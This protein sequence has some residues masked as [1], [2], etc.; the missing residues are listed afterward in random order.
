[1]I[2]VLVVVALSMVLAFLAAVAL[3]KFRFS[4]RAPFSSTM[5]VIRCCRRTR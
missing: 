4:G 3:A 1:V 2:I 5:I